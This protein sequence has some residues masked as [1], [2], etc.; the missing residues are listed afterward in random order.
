MSN[1]AASF[2][3]GKRVYFHF[4]YCGKTVVSFEESLESHSG[5]FE[6]GASLL[7]IIP[8]IRNFTYQLY[9]DGIGLTN[10]ECRAFVHLKELDVYAEY[11]YQEVF[12]ALALFTVVI[13][14]A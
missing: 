12:S 11:S 1:F 9:K 13:N 4:S 7:D 8:V 5:Q 14:N 3:F 6:V 10:Q 2:S